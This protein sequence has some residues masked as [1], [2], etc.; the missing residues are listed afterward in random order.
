MSAMERSGRDIKI[1][2][3]QLRIPRACAAGTVECALG[4]FCQIDA[5]I[6]DTVFIPEGIRDFCGLNTDTFPEL[7]EINRAF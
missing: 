4:I 6:F 1:D 5:Q 2:V 7:A 3:E